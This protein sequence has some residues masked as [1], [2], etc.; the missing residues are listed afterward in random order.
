MGGAV[1]VVSEEGVGTTF[2]I[3]LPTQPTEERLDSNNSVGNTTPVGTEPSREKCVLYLDDNPVNVKLMA[4]AFA[5]HSHLHLVTAVTPPSGVEL[6]VAYRLDAI[7]LDLNMQSMDGYKLLNVL[8]GRL[9]KTPII[10]L[11]AN[12][13]SHDIEKALSAGF[14]KCL[15]KPIDFGLLMSTVEGCLADSKEAQT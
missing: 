6:A 13:M 11:T 10:A 8:K 5:R 14:A 2:W 15:T 9:E 12:A 3:E 7:L 1:G 4:G